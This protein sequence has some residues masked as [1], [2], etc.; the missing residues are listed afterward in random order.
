MSRK[1][2]E[3]TLQG[4]EATARRCL[5]H[6]WDRA[7]VGSA[8]RT[9][10]QCSQQPAPALESVGSVGSAD[11]LILKKSDDR[12]IAKALLDQI[13]AV[14][15]CIELDDW[16]EAIAGALTCGLLAGYL[17][18]DAVKARHNRLVYL[19]RMLPS[20]WRQFYKLK[21]VEERLKT[22]KLKSVRNVCLKI[23]KQNKK[24]AQALQQAYSRYRKKV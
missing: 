8:S 4:F 5:D 1:R 20:Q 6:D 19:R 14:R 12:D 7:S 15:D 10:P 13:Q 18:P 24:A 16:T 22:G 23:E 21:E 11:K 2:I 17:L 3:A 9:E